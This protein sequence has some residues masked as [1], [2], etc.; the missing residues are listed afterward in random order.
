MNFIFSQLLMY[1]HIENFLILQKDVLEIYISPPSSSPSSPP[2][3]V[4]TSS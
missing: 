4:P 3:S 1:N 2:D